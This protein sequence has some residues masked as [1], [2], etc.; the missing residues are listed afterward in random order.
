M[1]ESRKKISKQTQNFVLI[2]ILFVGHI[3]YD[4]GL[5]HWLFR[6]A[7]GIREYPNGRWTELGGINWAFE[8]PFY[9]P[10]SYLMAK[11]NIGP[12]MWDGGA[13]GLILI[14]FA[15]V[16]IAFATGQLIRKIINKEENKFGEMYWRLVI[17]ILGWIFIPV[18]VEMTMT[19]EFTVLC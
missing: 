7:G 19:Y 3:F 13:W 15:S 10:G 4:L 8:T 18:P 12:C 5:G 11:S 17:V 2:P 16:I 6:L 9:V 1:T 14:L